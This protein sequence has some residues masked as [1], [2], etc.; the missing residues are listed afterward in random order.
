MLHARSPL[1]D[2]IFLFGL[3]GAGKSFVG[4]ALAARF[5]WK[6]YHADADLTTEMRQAIAEKR[7]FTPQMRDKYFEIVAST[8]LE[9][10]REQVPLIVT[11]AAYKQQHRKFLKEKIQRLDFVCV[12]APEQV[13]LERLRQRGDAVSPDYAQQMLKNFEPPVAGEKVLNNVGSAASVIDQ[14]SSWYDIKS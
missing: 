12:S 10:K 5:G 11:Q 13:I 1:P 4:D 6:V 9:L 3:A 2:V 14:F 7:L 8:I